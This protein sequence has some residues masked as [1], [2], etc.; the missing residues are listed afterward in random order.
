MS[1]ALR[2]AGPAGHR[3]DASARDVLAFLALSLGELQAS[4]EETATAWERRSYW[5]K[6]DRFRAEWSWTADML[7]RL[8]SNL[9][10]GDLDEAQACATELAG[11]LAGHRLKARRSTGEPWKGAWNAWLEKRQGPP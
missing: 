9:C 8:E 6:A 5:V 11:I 7:R 2:S 10:G 1:Q 4:I 3:A